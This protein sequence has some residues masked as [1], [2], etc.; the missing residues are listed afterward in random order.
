MFYLQMA[1]I[2]S[3]R[4]IA[5]NLF[6]FNFFLFFSGEMTLT[7]SE[8]EIK[9][10]QKFHYHDDSLLLLLAK[11][12]QPHYHRNENGNNSTDR[13]ITLRE[14]VFFFL[15]TKKRNR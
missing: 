5:Y 1:Q 9:E 2:A 6:F 4:F 11:Q 10:I 8:S 14:A 15:G 7:E 3:K 12:Q 13:V